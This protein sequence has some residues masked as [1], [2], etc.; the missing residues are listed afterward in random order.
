MPFFARCGLVV[1][2]DPGCFA[3]LE[4]LGQGPPSDEFDY[5]CPPPEARTPLDMAGS[6]EL[7]Q[8][9]NEV[10][11][12]GQLCCP[13]QGSATMSC[14]DDKN[15]NAH[16]PHRELLT[17]DIS[18]SL[19]QL[20]E[21]QESSSCHDPVLGVSSHECA[22]CEGAEMNCFE[23]GHNNPP[24][25]CPSIV[26]CSTPQ[27]MGLIGIMLVASLT[28]LNS[29]VVPPVKN[30][31]EGAP[32]RWLCLKVIGHVDGPLRSLICLF[33]ISGISAIVLHAHF[34]KL[35]PGE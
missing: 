19:A 6:R 33:A 23:R 24:E 3:L 16:E 13:M 22:T 28:A 30:P 11:H 7:E 26:E 32:S 5:M 21:L 2:P 31:R 20:Q 12:D 8:D 14:V 35:G 25:V 1:L 17:V 34:Q 15:L 18:E 9:V 10:E 4:D 27:V 29:S